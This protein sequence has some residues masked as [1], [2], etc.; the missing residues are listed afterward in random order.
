MDLIVVVAP[1][2]A[3]T[4]LYDLLKSPRCLGSSL[5]NSRSEKI[6]TFA[7]ANCRYQSGVARRP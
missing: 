2:R 1:D 3:S 4:E 5:A 6:H 7:K